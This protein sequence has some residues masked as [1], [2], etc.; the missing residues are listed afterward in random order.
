MAPD[1]NHDQPP[2]GPSS[3]DQLLGGKTRPRTEVGEVALHRARPDAHEL[4]G[5]LDG[6]AGFDVGGEDVHLA[7]SRPRREGA[8]QVSVS[9]AL[10]AVVGRGFPRCAV[11][12][13]GE[14]ISSSVRCSSHGIGLPGLGGWRAASSGSRR[15]ATRAPTSPRTCEARRGGGR[16]AR[17]EGAFQDDGVTGVFGRRMLRLPGL[18]GEREGLG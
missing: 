2:L 5:G 10:R 1:S 11:G 18:G 17:D 6:P 7:L 13:G 3:I 14:T 12:G 8:A 9:H 15:L 4:G 16:S